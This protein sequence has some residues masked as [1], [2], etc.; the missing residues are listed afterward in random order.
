MKHLIKILTLFL[1]AALVLPGCGKKESAAAAVG[2]DFSSLVKTGSMELEYATEFSVDFYE[3][4][5]A[6]I[7]V[8]DGNRYMLVPEGAEVPSGL[9]ANIAV[10]RQPI[11]HIYMAA[12]SAMDLYKAIGGVDKIRL[13][14]LEESGWYIPEARE[15]MH[16][17]AMLYAG[18]YSAP[19]YERIYSEDCDLAVESTMIYHVPEVKEQLERLG[20]PVFVE[21]SSYEKN[22]LGRMEW[23]KLHG[24]LIGKSEEAEAVFQREI[25][26]LQ[27]VLKQESTGKTVAFFAVNSNG[28]VTVR[29]SGDYIARTISMAG[30]EYIFSDLGDDSSALSTVNLQMEAFYK[31]AKDADILIYNSTLNGELQ[32]M[33]Q[34]L[35]QSSLLADFTA[36]KSGDVW[37][38]G[39]NLF[40]EGMGLGRLILEIHNVL[41]DTEADYQ[42]LH[43]LK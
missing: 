24:L 19:D 26:A 3:G 6:F 17:G 25:D 12:T 34:L 43:K 1:L 20:I 31:D 35:S 18:K 37:C 13:S 2:P 38:T 27:D 7:T 33:E 4:N 28:S 21:R 14:C 29:K 10:I 5:Y 41:T 36:V 16:S 22:P 39:Q 15:A 23:L 32:T 9:E 8:T 30:G 40:Q 11:N 42:Y